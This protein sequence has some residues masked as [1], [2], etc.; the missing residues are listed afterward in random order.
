VFHPSI[1]FEKFAPVLNV[2]V[3]F[4]KELPGYLLQALSKITKDPK[5]E[6]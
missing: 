1:S 2:K 4:M 6:K 3:F 5:M